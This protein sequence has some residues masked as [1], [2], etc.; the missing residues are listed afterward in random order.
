ML[1][2]IFE[3]SQLLTVYADWNGWLIPACRL[4]CVRCR[5]HYYLY[6]F[7]FNR[8]FEIAMWTPPSSNKSFSLLYRDK[9][10]RLT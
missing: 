10:N 3:S 1:R 2:S 5:P 6:H 4:S 9:P 7:L 8:F